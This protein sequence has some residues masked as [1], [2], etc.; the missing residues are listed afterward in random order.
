MTKLHLQ[1]LQDLLSPRLEPDFQS[2]RQRQ[3]LLEKVK[4]AVHVFGGIEQY[5]TQDSSSA[6]DNRVRIDSLA[7]V[8]TG[9]FIPKRVLEKANWFK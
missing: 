7:V 4:A 8:G 3:Q 5:I 2:H 6:D 9:K 1:R